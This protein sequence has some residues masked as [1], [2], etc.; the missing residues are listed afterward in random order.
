MTFPYDLG[1]HTRPIATASSETQTWFDRGLMSIYGFDLELAC[2][3]FKHA[4]EN[5]N[6]CVMAHWGLAYASGIYYNKPWTRMQPDELVE[7]L[8]I[9]FDES[10]YTKQLCTDD[11]DAD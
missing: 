6:D 7:K 1:T 11:S 5:D 3:C 10:R 4:I 8:K 9:T 2:N